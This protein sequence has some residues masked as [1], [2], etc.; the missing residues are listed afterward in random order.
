MLSFASVV[1]SPPVHNQLISPCV[2]TPV[3]SS[4]TWAVYPLPLL[5]R[6]LLVVLLLRLF[7]VGCWYVYVC[8]KLY[9]LTWGLLWTLEELHAVFSLFF[10]PLILLLGLSH[11]QFVFFCLNMD[12]A[13]FSFPCILSGL[14]DHQFMTSSL[15][16]WLSSASCIICFGSPLFKL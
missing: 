10:Q 11:S 7:I 16:V 13:C 9:I 8:N 14:C 12:A 2:T 1:S 3:N 5:S 15:D 4:V 6:A